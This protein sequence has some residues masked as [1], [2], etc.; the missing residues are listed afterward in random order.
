MGAGGVER[1][2]TKR[3]EGEVGVRGDDDG[4]E[5]STGRG[6][7]NA[8]TSLSLLS[9]PKLQCTQICKTLIFG[10]KPEKCSINLNLKFKS[11]NHIL[12]NSKMHLY[13]CLPL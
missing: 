2:G 12:Q 3:D 8:V 6:V 9:N 1:L 11:H 13:L 4:E 7:S 5:E 10:F